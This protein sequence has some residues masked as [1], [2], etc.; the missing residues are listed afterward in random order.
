MGHC[1]QVASVPCQSASVLPAERTPNIG[2][3][4]PSDTGRRL[5][6]HVVL[7]PAGRLHCLSIDRLGAPCQRRVSFAVQIPKCCRVW[8]SSGKGR[9]RTTTM[10]RHHVEHA[11]VLPPNGLQGQ[12]CLR[13]GRMRQRFA[14]PQSGAI[15]GLAVL[16]RIRIV[17][18]NLL[19]ERHGW[20]L[21]RRLPLPTA[22][23]LV[24]SGFLFDESSNLR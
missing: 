15:R 9:K 22:P 17:L 11:P 20:S 3:R 19:R 7:G 23:Q 14:V 21:M 18:R 4:C 10:R 24:R 12:R 1:V 8:V 2:F 16:M 13:R 5:E 6:R